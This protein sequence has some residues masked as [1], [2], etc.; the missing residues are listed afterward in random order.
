[1]RTGRAKEMMIGEVDA[2]EPDAASSHVHR[3]AQCHI[4]RV[5]GVRQRFRIVQIHTAVSSELESNDWRFRTDAV[6]ELREQGLCACL[7]HVLE[8][9]ATELGLGV[10]DDKI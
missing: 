3:E 4:R 9:I 5:P 8:A 10:E 7:F 6:L 2:E 1:M